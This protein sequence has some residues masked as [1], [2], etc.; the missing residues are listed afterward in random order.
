MKISKLILTLALVAT[1]MTSFGQLF[2]TSGTMTAEAELIVPLTVTGT[3]MDFKRVAIPATGDRYYH[4]LG[5]GSMFSASTSTATSGDGA[6]I[7]FEG[8]PTLGSV[9]VKGSPNAAVQLSTNGLVTMS[10]A[11]GDTIQYR[12]WFYDYGTTTLTITSIVLNGSGEYPMHL[13]GWIKVMGADNATPSTPGAYT[14][15]AILT[16]QY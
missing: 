11:G 8:S 6:Q 3:N 2:N 10:N 15:Y 4:V 1:S 9:V 13:G 7:D 12:P 14:G 16:A 5:D